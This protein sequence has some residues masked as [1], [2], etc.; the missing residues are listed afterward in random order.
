MTG[1][2]N[3]NNLIQTVAIL[4]RWLSAR[5]MFVPYLVFPPAACATKGANT[6]LSRAQRINP[7]DIRA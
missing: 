6:S 5:E 1:V 3:A 2:R 7:T 4:C